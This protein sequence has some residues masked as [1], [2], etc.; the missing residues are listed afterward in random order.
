MAKITE[1]GHK[2][3]TLARTLGPGSIILLGIGSLLG[4]GIFTLLGPAAGL[5][6]PGLFLAM[7]FGAGIAFLNLQMY[8]AL[9]TTF[10]EAGGGYLWVKKGLGNFQ[11]FLAGWLSWFAHAAACGVYAL[12]FGFYAHEFLKIIGFTLKL[13][14]EWLSNEKMI[15]VLVILIFGYINWRG[16]QTTGQA[17]NYITVGLLGIL[18]LFILFG[19]YKIATLPN[20]FQNFTPLLPSGFLGILAAASFFYIAFE[21]SEIQVQAGEETKNPS[22]DLKIGL[23]TSWAIVSI[24]YIL[25]SLIIVGATPSEGKPIWEVLAN[26]GEGAIVKSAHAF[27]PLGGILMIVGGLLANLAAL[28]ATIYSSSHVAFALARDK[29]IWTHLAQIHARNLTPHIAVIFSIA[30]IITMV[31]ALPLF[32]VA[33]AASLL[34]VLL[35][36]Q[37]NIAGTKIYYKFPKTKW[38]YKIPLFPL[39]PILAIILYIALAITMFQVNLNAWIVTVIWTLLGLINYLSYAKAQ[40]REDFEKEIVYEES[41]RVGPKTGR[42]ILMPIA[43]EL[44]LEELKNLS[45]IAFALA[46][47]LDGEIIAIKIHQVPQPLTL[48]DGATMIHDRQIFQNL[49]EWAAEFNEKMAG[50]E[51]DINLHNFLLVGRDIVDTI[52]D[53]IKIEECDLLLLN[54]EGYTETKG[55][56]FGSK[57]DRILRE[58]KCDLLVV[59]NPKPITSLLLAAHPSGNSPYLKLM[60]EIFSSLKNYYKAKTELTSILA[61]DTPF[62]LKP[63][64]QILLKPLGLKRKDF[65][66]IE[67]FKAKSVITAIIDEAKIKEISLVI[68]GATRPKF[69]GEIR[70]GNIPELL[71]KHLNTSLMIVRG[72]QNVAEAAWEKLLKKISRVS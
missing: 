33:S 67:F 31:I 22:H 2:P 8:L 71:S 19:S 28:N 65:E 3:V 61:A 46:S 11:G 36:L 58:S 55:T 72:H 38:F 29:N 5:A 17:G 4:G 70:F 63:D 47:N 40:S 50:R 53:V 14:T 1:I 48:L 45:E 6:G 64:P 32:D 7:I 56:I 25:I 16:T 26:F 57:I 60:G 18:G 49:K 20:P 10:P 66:E 15:A 59:K 52:L 62:Y 42:R 35:F 44:T 24:I 12:S 23:M 69:L 30:L 34:F 51:K 37:L 54:W 43:P 41:I 68:I 27:L 9:G 39:T 21:G 13:N